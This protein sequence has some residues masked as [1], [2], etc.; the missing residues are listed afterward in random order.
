MPSLSM[1]D[2]PSVHHHMA[3]R[4]LSIQVHPIPWYLLVHTQYTTPARLF[5]LD[6]EKPSIVLWMRHK[7]EVPP[8]Y[9]LYAWGSK[10]HQPGCNLCV[11]SHP[12]LGIMCLGGQVNAKI[13]IADW[14]IPRRRRCN[15]SGDSINF[16]CYCPHLA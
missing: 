5:G 4:Y 11:E 15:S 10:R 3:F 16:S 8:T 2:C 6:Y 12:W 13:G 1:T 7:I 14:N 9:L